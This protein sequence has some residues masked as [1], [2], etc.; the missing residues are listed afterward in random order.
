LPHQPPS[1]RFFKPISASLLSRRT[2]IR[3]WLFLPNPIQRQHEVIS[4]ESLPC[5]IIFYNTLLLS[6]VYEQKATTG[7]LEAIKILQ[8][9]SPV[10]W[11]NVHL[12]GNFG[13]TAG[14]SG[15]DIE[16]LAA[17]YQNEDFW[18][19]SMFE[20]EDEGPSV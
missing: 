1:R 14:S 17:H 18:R 15:V 6:R 19:R 12:I 8:S 13:S 11:R 20:A 2:Q 9:I 10:A 4:K 16:A 7:D 3:E 5:P